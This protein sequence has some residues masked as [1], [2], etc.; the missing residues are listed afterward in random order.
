MFGRYHRRREWKKNILVFLAHHIEKMWRD[1]VMIGKISKRQSNFLCISVSAFGR[2]GWTL[3]ARLY[4]YSNF[5]IRPSRESK[6]GWILWTWVLFYNSIFLTMPHL[7]FNYRLSDS[8]KQACCKP[9]RKQMDFAH[10]HFVCFHTFRMS[11][12]TKKT[13]QTNHPTILVST[14]LL[15]LCC[16]LDWPFRDIC[17]NGM[18]GNMIC[19]SIQFIIVIRV[20]HIAVTMINIDWSRRFTVVHCNRVYSTKNT[21]MKFDVVI[22]ERLAIEFKL[23]VQCSYVAVARGKNVC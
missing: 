3:N 14:E 9:N 16:A 2:I 23:P 20:A 13:Y 12:R 1:R 10:F 7:W 6:S 17:V 8:G 4:N 5:T 19:E 18:N 22:V 15:F 21:H 11:V